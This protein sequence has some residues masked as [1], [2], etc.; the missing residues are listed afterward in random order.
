MTMTKFS[1]EMFKKE[2]SDLNERLETLRVDIVKISNKMR[3]REFEQPFKYGE[4]IEVTNCL[5]W[6]TWPHVERFK[7]TDIDERILTLTLYGHDFGEV[8][9][10]ARTPKELTC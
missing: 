4:I 8:W 1:Q 7:E 10:Y 5:P 6:P 3:E 2:I 9:K